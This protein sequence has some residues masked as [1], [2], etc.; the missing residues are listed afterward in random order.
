MKEFACIRVISLRLFKMTLVKEIFINIIPESNIILQ[1]V[2]CL[3]YSLNPNL[4]FEVVVY[5]T[6]DM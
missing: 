2:Y 6:P 1:I 3:N 4:E 5:P